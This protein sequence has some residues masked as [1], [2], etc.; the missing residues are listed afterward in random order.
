MY[1]IMLPFTFD[2]KLIVLILAYLMYLEASRGPKAVHS[3]SP[4][5]GLSLLPS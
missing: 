5:N 2:A 4:L 3:A 1:S